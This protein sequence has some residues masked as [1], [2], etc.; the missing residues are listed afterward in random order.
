MKKN[1]VYSMVVA[2]L[3]STSLC[4]S[5]VVGSVNGKN[6][7]NEDVSSF[8][9]KI[10]PQLRY[11]NLKPEMRKEAVEQTAVS[12]LLLE[13]VKKSDIK[14]SKEFRDAIAKV[15]DDLS[16]K[17]WEKK[18]FDKLAISEEDIKKFYEANKDKMKQPVMM[19]AHHILVK[20]EDEAK[21]IISELLDEKDRLVAF[22]K[23]AK[24]KSID[25]GSKERGG[26]LDWFAVGQMVKPF[27][28]AASLLSP[29]EMTTQPV[30]S[31]FGYH[32][33]YL[34]DK[35]AERPLSVDEARGGITQI[36]KQEKFQITMGQKAKSL[37]EKAKIEVK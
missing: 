3:L 34:D 16:I 7:S 23:A 6:I 24:T 22:E 13:E 2:S 28:D 21:K 17:V 27:S 32:I 12:M 30:K 10:N 36:L 8:L 1:I 15:E 29:K 25:P 35:K 20:T 11:E 31:D 37:R 19:K 4:A 18:E 33:I 5:Q 26:S 14:K 9:M